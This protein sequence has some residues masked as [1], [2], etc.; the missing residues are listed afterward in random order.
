MFPCQHC[1]NFTFSL[2]Q[3][4]IGPEQLRCQFCG[5]GTPRASLAKPVGGVL[6]G[7]IA[8]LSLAPAIAWHTALPLCG[9]S[10]AL[11]AG[12]AYWPREAQL[13]LSQV[14]AVLSA[15]VLALASLGGVL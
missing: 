5:L 12:R 15:A 13:Q 7:L 2:L 14:W 6:M 3:G 1:R 11:I 4:A 9:L 10:L 8:F